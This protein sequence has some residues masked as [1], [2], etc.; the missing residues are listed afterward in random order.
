MKSYTMISK[1]LST[2]ASSS[3][4]R[5]K[6]RKL[7][8]SKYSS[9]LVYFI[10]KNRGEVLTRSSCMCAAQSAIFQLTLSPCVCVRARARVMLVV[11]VHLLKQ[12]VNMER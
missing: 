4:N 8:D 6:L 11:S 2:Q 10:N 9:D 3:G 7:C 1:C 5:H 12:R